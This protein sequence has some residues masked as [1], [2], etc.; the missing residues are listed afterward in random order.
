MV[1]G[2]VEETTTLTYTDIFESSCGYYLAIGM[3][4]EEYWEKEPNL[5]KYY[6]EAHKY[7]S[8]MKNEQ[9][10]IEGM[11]FAS[12]I[13]CNF[14]K[15]VK[16]PEKPFDI[17]PKSEL[18][19]KQEQENNRKKLIEYFSLFKQRWDNKNGTN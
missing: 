15:K 7:K 16:Y 17:F 4:F 9:L 6:R 8:K 11:Y 1:G 12:A 18:E 3:T 14:D 19:K 10:W 2:N 5:V 13:A